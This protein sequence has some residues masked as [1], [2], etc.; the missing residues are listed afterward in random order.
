[1][2]RASSALL[3]LV[4]L[5]GCETTKELVPL[6]GSKTDGTVRLGHDFVWSEVPIV[7][8]DKGEAV[9]AERCQAWGYSS[10]EQFGGYLRQCAQYSP[11]GSCVS[12]LVYYDYQCT[13]DL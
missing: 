12:Y 9:A 4:L 2:T 11:Y 10:A 5:A 7:D 8:L 1:M 13:G 3:A 6:G